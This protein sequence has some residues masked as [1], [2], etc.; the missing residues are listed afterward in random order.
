MPR[1]FPTVKS[2]VIFA[3]SMKYIPRFFD[4]TLAP[5]IFLSRFPF[6]EPHLFHR[7]VSGESTLDFTGVRYYLMSFRGHAYAVYTFSYQVWNNCVCVM[8]YNI[9]FLCE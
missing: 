8:L 1:S 2:N 3:E 6:A 9:F 4:K 5:V 7:R